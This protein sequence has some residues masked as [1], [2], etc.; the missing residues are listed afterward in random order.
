MAVLLDTIMLLHIYLLVFA[1][2]D[3]LIFICYSNK[4]RFINKRWFQLLV[5]GCIIL[6]GLATN[7]PRE[8]TFEYSSENGEHVCLYTDESNENI[9]SWIDLSIAGVIPSFVIFL[10]TTILIKKVKKSKRNSHQVSYEPN[11]AIVILKILKTF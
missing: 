2:I 3:R 5:T 7:I 4:L 10:S 11:F 9:Y 8:I 1:T 6:I